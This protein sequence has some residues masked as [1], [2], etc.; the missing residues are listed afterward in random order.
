MAPPPTMVMHIIP[1]LNIGGAEQ[2]LANLVIAQRAQPFPQAVVSLM[3]GG[4]LAEKISRA[5]VTVHELGM[6]NLIALPWTIPKLVF[7]IRRLQPAAI[8]SWLYYGDLA[9]LWALNMSGRRDATRL[10]WGIRS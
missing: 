7:L 4:A 9:A 2:T 10:Y 1:A 6:Q 8:Q 3:S 5:G